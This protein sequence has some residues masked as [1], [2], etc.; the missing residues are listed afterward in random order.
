[1]LCEMVNMPIEEY[2]FFSIML[3]AHGPAEL[4]D[5]IEYILQVTG[6]IRKA[7]IYH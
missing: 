1:M 3:R 5:R 4:Q 7:V 6:D 2:M